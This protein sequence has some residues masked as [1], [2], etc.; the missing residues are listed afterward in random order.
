MEGTMN[1]VWKG[2]TVLVVLALV[3]VLVGVWVTGTLKD[4]GP[5]LLV[6]WAASI[7]LPTGGGIGLAYGAGNVAETPGKGLLEGTAAG[8][9]G[10]AVVP[11][12]ASITMFAIRGTVEFPVAV[13]AFLTSFST[14]ALLG[15][16][17]GFVT[18]WAG[19]G[20]QARPAGS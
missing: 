18:A 8:L 1:R 9:A 10:T 6:F 20:F 7:F 16:A 11:A 15:A 14:V 4:P 19:A 3:P 17:A 2:T 13:Q 12:A 5:P